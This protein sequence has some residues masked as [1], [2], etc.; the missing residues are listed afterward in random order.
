MSFLYNAACNCVTGNIRSNNEDNLFFDNQI[1]AEEH[2]GLSHT[3]CKKFNQ[4]MLAFAV[5]DGMGG[6]ADGQIASYIAASSF[7][8]DLA[9]ISASGMF[10]ETI[11]ANIVAHMNTRVVSRASTEHNN[12]GTTVAAI[13]FCD[14]EVYVCNVGDSRIYRFRD[15]KLTQISMDHVGKLPPF[16]EGNKRR[17]PGLTQCIGMS[18][19][20]LSLEPY[21]VTGET[22]P[23]DRYLL[24]SDGLTDMVSNAEIE[25]ILAEETSTEIAVTRLTNL[26]LQNGGRDNTTIILVHVFETY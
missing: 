16:L 22:K 23:D 4:N 14:D 9:Q 25:M 17:K 15:R 20:E 19:D 12:M 26:A 1:L 21:I 18:Q 11:F 5:F 8:Q 24:C 7:K 3:V 2:A 6:A 10:S 13:G